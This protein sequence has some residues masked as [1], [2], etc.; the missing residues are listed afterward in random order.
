MIDGKNVFEQPF[1]NDMRTYDDIQINVAGQGDDYTT[2]CLLDYIYIT[3][4]I[5]RQRQQKIYA[6]SKHLM[7]IQKQYKK[8]M[9]M[10]IS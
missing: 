8:L 6:K 7:L 10:G 2:G 4:S 1:K 5:I 3:K 9:L